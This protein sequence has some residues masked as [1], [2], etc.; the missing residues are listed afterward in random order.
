MFNRND[1][2][3]LGIWWWT[4]DKWMLALTVLLAVV[5]VFLVMAASPPVAERINLS[6]QHFVIRHGIFL[7]VS[8]LAMLCFSMLSHRQIRIISLIALFGSMLLIGMSIM[9][10]PEIKGGIALDTLR[11]D[12]DTAI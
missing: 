12:Q 10:G 4:V 3:L 11:A 8:M 5:G 2:S 9:I 1:R 7:S 6:D